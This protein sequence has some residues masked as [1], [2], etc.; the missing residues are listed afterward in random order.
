[1][2]IF[3]L[4]S[5]IWWLFAVHIIIHLSRGESAERFSWWETRACHWDQWE[6]WCHCDQWEAGLMI[7][8]SA[9]CQ[10]RGQPLEPGMAAW[11]RIMNTN[12]II[13]IIVIIVS[14]LLPVN[15]T[16]ARISRIGL[17]QR[18]SNDAWS[19][20]LF[21]SICQGMAVHYE[22]LCSPLLTPVR[23]VS[24]FRLSPASLAPPLLPVLQLQPP[25]Q[26]DV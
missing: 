21:Y 12:I 2:L 8:L 1:M 23:L 20:W 18:R 6:A 13:V 22:L 4:A 15:I 5:E 3:D 10:G 16:R 24:L 14:I 19:L 26:G 11:L 9:L 25:V 7:V 17:S